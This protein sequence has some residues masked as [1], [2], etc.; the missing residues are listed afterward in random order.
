MSRGLETPRPR[1]YERSGHP[2]RLAARGRACHGGGIGTA[3]PG[4]A[5]RSCPQMRR[6]GEID[7]SGPRDSLVRNEALHDCTAYLGETHHP[8]GLR[9]AVSERSR[10]ARI[11]WQDVAANDRSAQNLVSDLVPTRRTEEVAHR[12]ASVRAYRGKKK[13]RTVR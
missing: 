11:H 2:T 3:R 6:L 5:G 13:R 10:S 8:L 1:R 9:L 12:Y 4:R 7:W